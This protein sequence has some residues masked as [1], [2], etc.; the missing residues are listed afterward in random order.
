MHSI[1]ISFPG[2][3]NHRLDARL[4]MPDNTPE[5]FAI[6]CHCFTCTKD[7]LT[8]YRISK[9]LAAKGLATLRFD[10]TGLGGSDGEFSQTGFSSNVKDV[11]AAINYLREHYQTPALLIGHSLGG[12]AILE[13]AL[14]LDENIS[15][16]VMA[17]VTIA[18]PSQPDHVLHHFGQALPLLERGISSSIDVAGQQ[19]NIEPEFIEDV[20]SYDMQHNLSTLNKAVLIFNIVGDALVSEE[21]AIELKQWINAEAEIIS[22]ENSDHLLSKKQHTDWVSDKIAQWFKNFNF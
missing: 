21:N 1:K 15:A 10:F 8:S 18:S 9:A 22:V 16:E 12:T 13:A 19:Y 2:G 7:T 3:N 5:A 14:Q 4:E 11:L 17:M 20:R 6:C